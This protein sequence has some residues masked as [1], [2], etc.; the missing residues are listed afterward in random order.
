MSSIYLAHNSGESLWFYH[1]NVRYGRVWS[2]ARTNQA[3]C[4]DGVCAPVTNHD[5]P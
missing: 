1:E 4:A 3:L 2:I 5:E